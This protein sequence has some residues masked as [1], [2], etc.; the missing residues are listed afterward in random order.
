[1]FNVH[2]RMILLFST[3]LL[4]PFESFADSKLSNG[5]V[6]YKADKD[7]QSVEGTLNCKGSTN[8]AKFLEIWVPEFQKFYPHVKSTSS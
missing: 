6:E 8:L 2:K 3:L 1:M 5:V 7:I 4:L